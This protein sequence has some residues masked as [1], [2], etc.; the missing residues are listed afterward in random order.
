MNDRFADL[1]HDGPYI[2]HDITPPPILSGLRMR[3]TPTARNESDKNPSKGARTSSQPAEED[4]PEFGLLRL[5]D[6]REDGLEDVLLLGALVLVARR[7]RVVVGE[8]LEGRLLHEDGLAFPH[9]LVF[10]LADEPV[11]GHEGHPTVPV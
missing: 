3:R 5:S 6:P 10:E 2:F 4:L 8:P 11:P 1:D 7:Q 9:D